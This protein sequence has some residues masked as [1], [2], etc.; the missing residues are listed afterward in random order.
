[1]IFSRIPIVVPDVGVALI[2]RTCAACG[3]NG[4][5]IMYDGFSRI[6][7][8]RDTRGEET[9]I[10]HHRATRR[11]YLTRSRETYH[12]SAAP[13]PPPTLRQGLR[14]LK[15]YRPKAATCSQVYTVVNHAI[16]RSVALSVRIKIP[17]YETSSDVFKLTCTRIAI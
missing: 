11:K 13:P 3:H 2:L 14:A 12:C 15:I 6:P 5:L 7:G 4:Y 17:S 16:R 1:L 9:S 10:A 8:T